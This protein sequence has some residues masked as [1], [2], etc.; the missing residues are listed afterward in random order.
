MY[1]YWEILCL[2]LVFHVS[3]VWSLFYVFGI[4]KQPTGYPITQNNFDIS[5]RKPAEACF[6]STWKYHWD[7]L[8]PLISGVVAAVV[9]DMTYF[10]RTE[11]LLSGLP[12]EIWRKSC[13]GSPIPGKCAWALTYWPWS[14]TE[15]P[16]G[17]NVDYS[18]SQNVGEQLRKLPQRIYF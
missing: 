1:W 9:W 12:R 6:S 10:M 16:S 3:E 8:R 18:L 15:I 17:K 11:I 5:L 2:C 4:Q 7:N 13:P 14:L